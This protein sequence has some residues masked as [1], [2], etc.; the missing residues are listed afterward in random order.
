MLIGTILR[1][2]YLPSRLQSINRWRR[3][4]ED[5]AD[6]ELIVSIGVCLVCPLSD[7]ICILVLEI[8]PRFV[9]RVEGD[10]I[11]ERAA[12][13]EVNCEADDGHSVRR[14]MA[15]AIK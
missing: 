8:H 10:P 7:Q 2:H 14:V 3:A 13:S 4:T 15:Q 9:C 5:S 1:R 6:P 12:P 11:V